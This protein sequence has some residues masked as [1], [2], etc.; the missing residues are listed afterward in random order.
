[1]AGGS[2]RGRKVTCPSTRE[3]DLRTNV[4]YCFF[5]KCATKIACIISQGRLTA[6]D[7][8]PKG[9]SPAHILVSCGPVGAVQVRAQGAPLL[10]CVAPLHSRAPESSTGLSKPSRQQGESLRGQPGV[11]LTSTTGSGAT[12]WPH[13]RFPLHST[14][15][16]PLRQGNRLR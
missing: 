11:H 6:V 15:P 16:Q 3:M 13:G 5:R 14:G 1:M 7:N 2:G 10:P 4:I 9:V 8:C 12:A